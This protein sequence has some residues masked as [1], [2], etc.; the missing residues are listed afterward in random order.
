MKL[1]I[2]VPASLARDKLE[3][4]LAELGVTIVERKAKPE[5]D[6]P[7]MA[8]RKRLNAEEPGALQDE[9]GYYMPL[10]MDGVSVAKA[11]R[12]IESARLA[13]NRHDGRKPADFPRYESTMTT[14][15]YV[16]VIE[17]TWNH[18]PAERIAAEA[19]AA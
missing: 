3:R 11:I 2:N 10:E 9:D 6:Y 14:A 15:D 19:M 18:V 16:A 8:Y 17:R 4:A 1:T 13:Y 7:P 5:V 12:K